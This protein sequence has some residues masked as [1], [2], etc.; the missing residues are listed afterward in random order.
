M[1]IPVPRAEKIR[2]EILNQVNQSSFFM[3][4]SQK[5]E[6]RSYLR[7][8]D[9]TLKEREREIRLQIVVGDQNLQFWKEQESLILQTIK[10]HHASVHCC[11]RSNLFCLQT[12]VTKKR[13][14]ILKVNSMP[15]PFSTTT[16]IQCLSVCR[17]CRLKVVSTRSP[18]TLKFNI[19][20]WNVKGSVGNVARWDLCFNVSNRRKSQLQQKSD[21]CVLSKNENSNRPFFWEWTLLGFVCSDLTN[22][23]KE[24]GQEDE[25]KEANMLTTTP[26]QSIRQFI[27]RRNCKK[28]HL[29]MSRLF[30]LHL[31]LS[32]LSTHSINLVLEDDLPKDTHPTTYRPKKQ[33]CHIVNQLFIVFFC[34]CCFVQKYE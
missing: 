7:R 16:V 27:D 2:F 26:K 19:K 28:L 17:R 22:V 34:C 4:K 25:E 23:W 20:F 15:I 14:Q 6:G 8:K 13:N 24:E 31:V 29:R 1:E 18:I 33:K 10:W 30:Q 12:W 21:I 32:S 5:T 3:A 9:E 11:L